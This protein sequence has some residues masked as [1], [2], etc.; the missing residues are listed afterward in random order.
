MVQMPIIDASKC[1]GCGLCVGICKC[2]VLVLIENKATVIKKEG[3]A[4]CTRWC[5]LCED[6]CPNEAIR[7]PFEI[8]IEEEQRS[9]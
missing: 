8:I 3:C 4:E 9:V 6:I 7:C 1:N 5:T 2:G